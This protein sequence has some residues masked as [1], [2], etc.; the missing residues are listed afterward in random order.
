MNTFS[1]SMT[2]LRD[3]NENIESDIQS[4]QNR[5]F[6]NLIMIDHILFKTNAYSSITLGRKVG[7]FGTHHEC[8]LGKWYDGDGKKRF[9]H[10][11]SFKK[12]DKPHS[13]VHHNVINSVKCV[14]GEDTCLANSKMILEDFKSMEIASSELFE[15]AENMID[16]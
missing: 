14:E 12:M 4:I 6:V 8:R 15:L 10:S 16:E 11:A 5:I 1:S 3:T 2:E 13:V 9:G 7:S